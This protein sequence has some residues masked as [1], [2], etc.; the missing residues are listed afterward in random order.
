MSNVSSLSHEY[1]AN[2]LFAEEINTLVLL[3]KKHVLRPGSIDAQTVQETKNKLVTLLDGM[4]AVLK[5]EDL[6]TTGTAET[7]TAVPP[8]VLEK[9]YEQYKNKLQ[10]FLEDL[11]ETTKRLRADKRVDNKGIN[12][13]DE[14]C[15]VTDGVASNAFRRLWRR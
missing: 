3:L 9:I 15:D 4:L 11:Q 14:L 8:E 12:L 6:H 2:A 5:S 1:E 7:R 13:L 10:Y